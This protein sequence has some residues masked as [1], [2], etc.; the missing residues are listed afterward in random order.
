MIDC[1]I[2]LRLVR[3][4]KKIE[5]SLSNRPSE[6]LLSENRKISPITSDF[7]PH[8]FPTST[9]KIP[10]VTVF[11]NTEFVRLGEND[12]PVVSLRTAVLLSRQSDVSS[13]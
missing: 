10:N 1:V 3:I 11:S 7:H 13:L 9:E 2:F 6:K 12:I 4:V 5:G 8:M